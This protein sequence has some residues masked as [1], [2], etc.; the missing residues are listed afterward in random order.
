MLRSGSITKIGQFDTKGPLRVGSKWLTQPSSV[1]TMQG[2]AGLSQAKILLVVVLRSLAGPASGLVRGRDSQVLRG[3]RQ[4]RSRQP[5][6]MVETRQGR[7][8]RRTWTYCIL[9]VRDELH[10]RRASLRTPKTQWWRKPL[11]SWICRSDRC[12]S[13]CHGVLN[14]GHLYKVL[15]TSS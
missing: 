9:L 1:I 6:D 4:S 2:I 12:G 13:K 7:H 3:N 5:E 10:G 11:D 8:I 15:R 14:T